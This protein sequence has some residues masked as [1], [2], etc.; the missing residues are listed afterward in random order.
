MNNLR[1]TV[2]N[3]FVH[4]KVLNEVQAVYPDGVHAVLLQPREIREEWTSARPP[5]ICENMA[6]RPGARRNR[7]ARVVGA[8][9]APRP[10]HT[11]LP[12]RSCVG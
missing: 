10:V 8:V 4:K 3:E 12:V 6:S 1:V 9:G 2:F 5:K 7:C 11:P